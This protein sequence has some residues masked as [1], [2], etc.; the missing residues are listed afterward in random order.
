M[1]GLEKCEWENSVQI[2]NNQG[3]GEGALKI[4]QVSCHL[5]YTGLEVIK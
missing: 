5:I 4:Y 3:R 1:I 2:K